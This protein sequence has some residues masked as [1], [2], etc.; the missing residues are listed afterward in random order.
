MA[1]F[2][3]RELAGVR[4]WL[5]ITSHRVLG[6]GGADFDRLQSLYGLVRAHDGSEAL[7]LAVQAVGRV[8]A[9]SELSGCGAAARRSISRR[10][11][12]RPR[13]SIATPYVYMYDVTVLAVAVAFLLRLA[14]A[15]GFTSGI[16]I[17]ALAAAG[18]LILM[19]PY[20]K[21]QVGL[22]A[23]LIVLALIVRRALA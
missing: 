16:E 9:Q 15:R 17:A 13:R 3:Q 6:E 2:R 1:R 20:V 12:S 5:P 14:L 11:R 22:A 21:T 7:A 18:A 8:A 4:S 10:Q 23:V 19:F